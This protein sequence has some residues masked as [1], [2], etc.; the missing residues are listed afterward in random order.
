MHC[1]GAQGRLKEAL[2]GIRNHIRFG[3]GALAL[4]GCAGIETSKLTYDDTQKVNLPVKSEGCYDASIVL[5]TSLADARAMARKVLVAIDSTI[6]EE[7]DSQLKAQRNRHIGVFVGSGGEELT[8]TLRGIANGRTYLTATTKTG[9]VGGAGQKA[10][11]CQI[12][13]ELAKMAA[14]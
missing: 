9:F 2:M 10:W 3:V 12:V 13:D 1:G 6:G 7:T 5:A 11:S 8:V 4:A 14:P